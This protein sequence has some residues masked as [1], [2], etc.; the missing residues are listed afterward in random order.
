MFY[1]ASHVVSSAIKK[2]KV[3]MGNRHKNSSILS[4]NN[5]IRQHILS[6]LDSK[7]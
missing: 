5:S 3:S 7:N 4:A 6:G 2:R 1:N